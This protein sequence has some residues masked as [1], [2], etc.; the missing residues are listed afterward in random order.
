MLAL[1]LA[2]ACI[3]PVAANGRGSSALMGNVGGMFPS[4]LLRPGPMPSYAVTQPSRDTTLTKIAWPMCFGKHSA[5]LGSFCVAQQ[6]E[7]TATRHEL[8]VDLQAAPGGRVTVFLFGDEEEAYGRFWK[9][10]IANKSC[11]AMGAYAAAMMQPDASGRVQGARALSGSLAH[12]WYVVA[13][14]CET[15]QCPNVSHVDIT[16]RHPGDD[17]SHQAC[18]QGTMSMSVLKQAMREGWGALS[19]RN[20]LDVVGV[21]PLGVVIMYVSMA[22]LALLA[23]ALLVQGRM[24]ADEAQQERIYVAFFIVALSC[25]TYLVMATGG[26]QITH[27]ART[28]AH[29]HT[30]RQ[31][32]VGIAAGWCGHQSLLG[33]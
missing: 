27:A 8:I 21:T 10:A 26:N 25:A 16:F 23:A 20:V 3:A 29:T 7:S 5:M 24:A 15:R 12:L 9:D 6:D 2:L 28:H 31:W 11:D 19:L 22:L 33:L 30:H 1:A 4:M 13:V 18:V 32:V 17:G 14:D